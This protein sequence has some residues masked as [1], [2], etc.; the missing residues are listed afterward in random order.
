MASRNISEEVRFMRNHGTLQLA[1]LDMNY[2]YAM[3]EW[4]MALLLGVAVSRALRA[5][6]GFVRPAASKQTY[7]TEI[8]RY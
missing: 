4:I 1:L 6:L 5:V 3:D 2:V 7:L 8:G